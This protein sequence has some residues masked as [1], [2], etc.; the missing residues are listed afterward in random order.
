M[1]RICSLLVMIGLAPLGANAQTATGNG[2]TNKVPKFAYVAN[3][4]SSNVSAYAIDRT[5]GALTS[6]PGSPFAAGSL[7]FSVA[8]DS[9]GKFAYVANFASNNVSAYTIDRTTGAL[10]PVPGS[11]FA[12][13]TNPFS[14][15]VDPSGNFAY[16]ANGCGDPACSLGNVSAYTIDRTTGALSP[17]PGSPFAAGSFPSSVTVDSSGNF[18]YVANFFSNNVSAYSINRTTGALSPIPG[19]PFA[20]GSNPRSVT[21]HPSANFA[22]VANGGGNIS[23]YTIDRTTGALSPV[24]GSPFAAGS[25]PP[26]VAVDPTGNFAYVANASSD[27]VSAYSIDRTTGSLSP[28]PGSPFAEASIPFSV[29]VDPSGKFAYVANEG[30]SN[31]SAYTIDQTTGSLSPVP[32]SPFAAGTLPFSVAIAG[33]STVPFAAFTLEAEIA[34]GPL[35]AFEVKGNF[36]LGEGSN[37][38]NPLTEDVKLQ[39]GTF[40]TTIPA[41]SFH[42]DH[43]GRFKFEGVINGVSLEVQI[44]PLGGNDFQFKA[45]AQGADMMDIVNPVS[46]ELTIGDDGGSA[47]VTAAFDLSL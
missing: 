46:V 12:A 26:S 41:G 37:G 30:S 21:A 36:T 42:Q 16:V 45:E 27:N 15:A 7:P 24:P 17:V 10:S 8:V 34:L 35:G 22:Y 11:P 31:V 19:S 5:T 18:T 20:A 29:A 1:K 6:V 4:N 2:R 9:S 3:E 43:R 13:S 32:G 47:T 23:A 38:I 25:N 14:V 44:V 28:V 33:Q 40:S 39:V